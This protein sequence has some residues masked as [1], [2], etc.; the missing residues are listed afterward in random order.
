MVVVYPE[1]SL[2][3][4]PDLW[5]MRGKTG[6]VRI[7]LERD[8]PI[9]PAA[10]WG[11]QALLAALR[12]EAQP[13]PP[14]D[15]RRRSIGEPLDLSAYRGKPLDQASLL[16]A[17][18]ELMDAI[19]ALLAELRGEPAPAERWDPDGAR[20]EGDGS[21]RWLGHPRRKAPGKRVA[22]LGAG[23]WGTTFAK[24][25]ADGGADVVMW[26]RRPELA[27]EIQEAKRNSDYL[28]GVNLPLGLRATSRL[29]LALAGAEQVYV[30]VPSQ[31]LR[32]NLKV[33]GAAPPRRG[34][35]GVAHEG[36]REG[37]RHAHERGHRRGA[38]GSTS[39]RSRS[40]PVRT[41]RS[42]SRRSSRPRRSSRRRASR[43]RSPW[44]P[45]PATA[46]STRS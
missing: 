16:K 23:S 24:I 19:A 46:T 7:A 2:T 38:A 40:S 25:L 43:P 35:R 22:V 39:P 42:R 33:A 37:D 21:T 1:G 17:T 36:R 45:W 13:V 15:H 30:S 32:D 20:P 26:A 29:D 9:I 34:D 11:T 27:R 10:H 14:Q 31:A 4:E 18:G 8:I 12:Q 41:S 28:A 6:A 3:R 5:P 44:H